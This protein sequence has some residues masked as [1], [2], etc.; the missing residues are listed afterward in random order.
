MYID[1]KNQSPNAFYHMLVQTV[2][3]R[4]IAWTLTDN[5]TGEGINRYNLAP[6]SFFNAVS[7]Q[8][9]LLMIAFTRKT[10][11]SLKDTWTNLETTGLATIHIT[12]V[13]M[14]DEMVDTSV[15][16]PHGQ[17]ELA[18]H[19]IKLIHDVPGFLPRIEGP[20]VAFYCQRESLTLFEGGHSGMALC[21]IHHMYVADDTCTAEGKRLTVNANALNP[22]ARL[23]GQWYTSLGP[24]VER[25]RPKE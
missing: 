19:N 23:G 16:L 6:F 25:Q 21:R 17:T 7:A 18:R 12:P 24:L 20:K 10:D 22:V 5:G 15:E 13:S 9:P 2:L 8:P 14:L 1:P 3:P 4:P 11:G